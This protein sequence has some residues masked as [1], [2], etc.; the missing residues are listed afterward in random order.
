MTITMDCSKIR[1]SFQPADPV[2]QS[3]PFSYLSVAAASNDG[4]SHT[5]QVYSDISAEWISGDNS[6]DAQWSTTTGDVITHQV[7]LASQSAF[8]ELHDHIQREH[9]MMNKIEPHADR[10]YRRFCL[11]FNVER[12]CITICK[13]LHD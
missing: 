9:P 2:N 4:Q 5:V 13:C 1:Y 8:T 3:L 12:M 10:V 11:S 6:L 7:Q